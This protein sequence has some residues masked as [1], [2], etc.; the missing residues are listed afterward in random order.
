[1]YV[2]ISYFIASWAFNYSHLNKKQ[3]KNK[4]NQKQKISA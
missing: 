1:M 4:Q 2:K 3:K